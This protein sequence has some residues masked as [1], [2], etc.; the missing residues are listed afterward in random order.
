MKTMRI[1][2]VEDE[3]LVAARAATC[4]DFFSTSPLVEPPKIIIQPFVAVA[5]W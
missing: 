1:L 3:P 5:T 4:S 2:I